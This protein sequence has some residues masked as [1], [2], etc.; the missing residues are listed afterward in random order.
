VIAHVILFEPR[1]DLTDAARREMLEALR[2]ATSKIPSVRRVRVGRR[3]THG[4][5]GYEQ[6]M[7]LAY[8]FAAIIEFDDVEGLRA[9]LEHPDHA[10]IGAHFHSS[11]ASALA[12][13]YVMTDPDGSN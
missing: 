11:A 7:L 13:D 6:A 8:E 12:Y 10:A 1:A 4:L 3:I 9:Y 5:P 2:S